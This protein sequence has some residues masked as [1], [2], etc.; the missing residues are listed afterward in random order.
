MLACFPG[1]ARLWF[2]VVA[3]HTWGDDQLGRTWVVVGACWAA[4]CNT[5]GGRCCIGLAEGRRSAGRRGRV[6][7]G[8]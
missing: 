2:P 4:C 3:A 6:R 1:W 7:G 8:R 5:R